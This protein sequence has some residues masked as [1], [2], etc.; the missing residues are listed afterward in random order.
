[1]QTS[2][3][4]KD[5]LDHS[6][7]YYVERLKDKLKHEAKIRKVMQS[8]S[9]FNRNSRISGKDPMKESGSMV[10]DSS[11]SRGSFLS[12]DSEEISDAP[13]TTKFFTRPSK[14]S[15]ISTPEGEDNKSILDYNA[16]DIATELAL[17]E[18]C[19]MKQI[20]TAELIKQ[21]WS[22]RPG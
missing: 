14:N 8:S 5:F 18:H 21:Q 20:S 19:I 16:S 15:S 22:K 10:R 6:T 7:H 12:S 13:V 4:N 2:P 1:M 11:Y 9:I 17:M 3:F